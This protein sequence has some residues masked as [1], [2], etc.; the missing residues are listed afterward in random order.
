MTYGNYAL[1]V[2]VFDTEDSVDA[3]KLNELLLSNGRQIVVEAISTAACDKDNMVYHYV[4]VLYRSL[5]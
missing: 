2:G 4:T 5:K 1:H 3:R